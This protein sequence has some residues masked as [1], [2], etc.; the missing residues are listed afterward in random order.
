MSASQPASGRSG[1][2]LAWAVL[3]A[4]CHDPEPGSFFGRWEEISDAGTRADA[5]HRRD[6]ATPA[7]AAMLACS[8]GEIGGEEEDARPHALGRLRPPLLP[9]PRQAPTGPRS[10]QH[11]DDEEEPVIRDPRCVSGYRWVGGKEESKLMMPGSDCL[12]CHS[13]SARSARVHSTDDDDPDGYV[14]AGTV[15]AAQHEPSDCLG[16]GGVLIRITD[17]R[18][19]IIERV[20]NAA[21]N[22]Y[23]KAEKARLALP[24]TA[25]IS[26]GG[27]T[28]KMEHAQCLTSC[29]ACHTQTGS[30]GAPGRILLP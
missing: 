23:I 21:G 12:S 16:V 26:A 30:G 6:A 9:A 4:A 7:D 2:L 18:G 17:A 5:A 19:Q 29:N 25:E 11:D 14:V 1:R 28:R 15:Y 22:F 20:S 13:P 8:P 10:R 24:I 3:L 27:R